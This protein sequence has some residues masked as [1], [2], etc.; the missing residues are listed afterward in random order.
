M[1]KRKYV[2][3]IV[4]TALAAAAYFIPDYTPKVAIQNEDYADAR[5]RFHTKL[6]RRGP[7]PQDWSPRKL[8]AGV[9]EVEY[10]SS[11]WRLRA[12]VNR[13]SGGDHRRY[14][15][16]LFLHGGNSFDLG[17][18]QTSQPYRDAGFVVLTPILRGENR[19]P[20]YFSMFYDEVE[21]V[22]TAAEYLRRQPYV[23]TRRLFVAGHSVGG[24]MVMLSAMTYRH[25]RAAAALSGSPDQILF[26]RYA[27]DASGH[28]PYDLADPREAQMR[29]PLAYAASFKCP[30][31]IYYGSEENYFDLTSRRTAELARAHGLDVEA[32]A[33]DGNHNTHVPASIK[34]SI[35][36]FRHIAET[37]QRAQH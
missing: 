13:P 15:T 27:P 9:A 8:P 7:A 29:S 24:T 10:A 37:S 36:F 34:L 32:L 14:P 11:P 26:V 18:W 30:V 17:D 31:R 16:V 2:A 28:V 1:R 12:W 35:Q 33:V 20:G 3:L 5:K 6:V 21:D 22:V 19:Q 23:D 25:F 4:L